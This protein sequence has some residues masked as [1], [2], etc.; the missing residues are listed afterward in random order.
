MSLSVTTQEHDYM[1]SGDS[2][3]EPELNPYRSMSQD[4]TMGWTL[5]QFDR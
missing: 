5:T 3:Y 2:R 1:Y 4:A